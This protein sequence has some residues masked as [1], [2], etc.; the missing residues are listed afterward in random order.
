MKKVLQSLKKI[1]KH[2]YLFGTILLISS[3]SKAQCDSIFSFSTDSTGLTVSFTPQDQF[4]QVYSWDFGD[5]TSSNVTNPSYTYADTGAYTVCLTITTFIQGQQ[6]QC[7]SC[8][9]IL[10]SNGAIIDSTAS[11]NSLINFESNIFPNPFKD[12]ITIEIDKNIQGIE[13]EVLDINSKILH[14]RRY[15]SSKIQ[16]NTSNLEKG[17]YFVKIVTAK[18]LYSNH[19]II[20]Q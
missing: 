4:A 19:K 17:I 14:K 7:S 13:I 12:N 5:G 2:Y 15:F 10:I 16:I 11:L 1:S 8:Q 9:N 6:V 3:M 20:K 18:G